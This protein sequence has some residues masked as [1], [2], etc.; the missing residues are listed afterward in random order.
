MAS[1]K[2]WK[3]HV[4]KN[5]WRQVTKKVHHYELVRWTARMRTKSTKVF[6]AGRRISLLSLWK[7]EKKSNCTSLINRQLSSI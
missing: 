7:P 5:D 6:E 3:G 4:D 1:S 2:T